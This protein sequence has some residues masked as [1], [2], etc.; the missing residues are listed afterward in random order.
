[1]E[2]RLG[3]AAACAFVVVAVFASAWM[4]GQFTSQALDLDRLVGQLTA[5]DQEWSALFRLCDTVAG[6]ACLAGVALVIRV[7]EEWQGWLAMAV[8]G[9]CTAVGGLFPLDCAGC[10]GPLSFAH[11]AHV[12]AS[13]AANAAVLV[14][15]AVLSARW[16]SPLTWLLTAATFAA[17]M[18]T[19]VADAVGRYAGLAQR[20]QVT[21]VAVWLLYLATRLLVEATPSLDSGPVHAVDEGSGHLVLLSSGPGGAWFHWEAVAEGLRDGHRVLRF[22]RPG[23]GL[24]PAVPVPPTLYGEAA[25]LAAL[26][27]GSERATVV[28]RSVAAWHAEAFARLHPLRV[29]RLVLVEPACRRG[30]NIAW[31]GG[32]RAW[33]PALGAT[34]GATAL[35]RTLGSLTHLLRTGLAD[36]HGVYRTGRVA[37]AV[38]GE[39]LAKG[40]MAADLEEVRREH[41]FPSV[42]VTVI[43]TGG[44]CAARLAEYLG[45]RL[46]VV[47]GEGE[48]RAA[49]VEACQ[50]PRVPG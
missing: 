50:E 27:P 31:A 10:G 24:S 33:A 7:R 22:D 3:L 43:S 8:F 37:A 32:L 44:G 30:P 21:L 36:P 38:A 34:W 15:M 17:T 1:M 45:A 6:L 29:A 16:R 14:A 20:L 11:R 2:R 48:R 28:A 35:A 23:L 47:A 41:P 49:V 25:R 19:F 9:L 42:P 40:E 5:G 26:V 39:W 4:P 13:V 12:A 18:A 46:V